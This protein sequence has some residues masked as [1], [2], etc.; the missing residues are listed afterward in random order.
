MSATPPNVSPAGSVSGYS[1]RVWLARN[2]GYLK[3]LVSIAF[4]L[5]TTMLPQITNTNLSIAAGSAVTLISKLA[6]DA[7][8][9]WLSD[10]AVSAP[11]D[12]V[13]PSSVA[14]AIKRQGG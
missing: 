14:D 2:K 8:D 6:L 10:V 9:F 12:S 4:G 11:A 7:I 13:S 3:G 5:V 1:L